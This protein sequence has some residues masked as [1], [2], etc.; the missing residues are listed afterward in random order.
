MKIIETWVHIIGPRMQL[1][2]LATWTPWDPHGRLSCLVEKYQHR[3]LTAGSRRTRVWKVDG[4]RR[5]RKTKFGCYT[6]TIGFV[7]A[8]SCTHAKPHAFSVS[9]THFIPSCLVHLWYNLFLVTSTLA[10][11]SRISLS[12]TWYLCWVEQLLICMHVFT[13]RDWVWSWGRLLIYR[14]T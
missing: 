11:I 10:N 6:V 9:L 3:A 7:H 5:T 2:G 12:D 1:S 13:G 8:V 4:A 14:D